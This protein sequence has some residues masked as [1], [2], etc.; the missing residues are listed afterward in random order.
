M[1][2]ALSPWHTGQPLSGLTVRRVLPRYTVRPPVPHPRRAVCCINW[3]QRHDTL[4]SCRLRCKLHGPFSY[5]AGD[6]AGYGWRR[7]DKTALGHAERGTPRAGKDI[8][9]KIS[10]ACDTIMYEQ[11]VILYYITGPTCRVPA[12]MYA[13]P[14]RYKREALAVQDG[15]RTDTAHKLA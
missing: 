9:R 8:R 5:V 11:Y 15:A 7:S 3:I 14:L 10:F 13:P 1:R 12:A 4:P 2:R 6:A